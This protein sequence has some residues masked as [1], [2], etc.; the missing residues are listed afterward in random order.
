MILDF[1]P[2]GH[3]RHLHTELLDTS[4]L[5]PTTAITRASEVEP[6]PQTLEWE[7]RPVGSSTVLFTHPS[8]SACLAWEDE[9]ILDHLA[10][11]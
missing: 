6:N 3:V 5:G 2:G 4:F 11:S 10:H 8:R 1:A 9:H 7:V